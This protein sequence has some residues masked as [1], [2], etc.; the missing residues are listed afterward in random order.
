MGPLDQ[1]A[2]LKL[3]RLLGYLAAD[4]SNAALLIDAIETALAAG[5]LNT[6]AELVE[7]LSGIRPDSFEAAYF[8]A[9]LAMEGRDFEKAANSLIPLVAAGAPLNARFNLAWCQAMLGDKAQALANLDFATTDTLASAAML[10]LQLMHEAGDIDAAYVFGQDALERF[11]EDVG[12]LAAMATLAMDME[13][14]P[15]ARHCAEKAGSH[16]EAL[17]ALGLL[18][19]QG[20]N[21]ESARRS[22]EGS[23]AIRD[24][25]PR[26]WV[27]QGLVR[28]LER[29]PAAAALDM[30]RGAQQFGDHIG[31]WIGAGWA[32]Y[33]AGNLDAAEQRFERALAIDP[34]FAESHGSLAVID[35]AKGRT[36]A[37]KRRMI[38]AL[39]LDRNCFSALLAKIMLDADNPALARDL[40]EQAFSS[41]LDEN[42]MTVSA[43]LAGLT[44]P[45][46]H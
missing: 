14:V 32:H 21:I 8:S 37:A 22:L 30:D 25:N 39:R 33:L 34:N 6:A 27:G 31:S 3:E 29:E 40:V 28:L 38:T 45:T 41:P 26:A 5:T 19:L 15:L 7:Q 46:I 11:P 18:D 10:R 36:E 2:H 43:F 16:P 17:A 4:P 1:N 42:G 24:H 9:L 44:K 12:L 20:G 23:L 35:V 13:D